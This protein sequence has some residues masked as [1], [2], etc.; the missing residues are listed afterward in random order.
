[1]GGKQLGF[2]INIDRCTGCLTCQI[3]CK[4]K[5]DLG[6]G[7]SFRQVREIAGGGYTEVNNAFQSDVFAYWVSMSCNHCGEP[8]CVRNCPTG[9]MQ[10]RPGDGIVVVDL[11]QCTGCQSCIRSCPYGAPQY[12]PE[13]GRVRKCDFCL[14]LLSQGEAPACVDACPMQAL[15][16]GPIDELKQKYGGVQEVKGVPEPLFS[17]PSIVITPHR[18]VFPRQ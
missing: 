7:L 10:K 11:E 6:P 8:L 4:D 12:D 17:K 16:C 18:D 5:N 9:A 14:D 1:M 3:A 2:H 13:Q 15:D